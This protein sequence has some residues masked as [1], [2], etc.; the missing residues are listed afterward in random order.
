[1]L[2]SP[3]AEFV[4]GPPGPS[5]PFSRCPNEECPK[6]LSGR[7]RE[8][9][10]LQGRFK[11]LTVAV[12]SLAERE[13]DRGKENLDFFYLAESRATP[14]SLLSIQLAMIFIFGRKR[15][16]GC[17]L[18]K[19]FLPFD[20]NI[21]YQPNDENIVLASN[22]FCSHSQMTKMQDSKKIHH[23]L[24][25]AENHT[26]FLKSTLLRGRLSGVI[27]AKKCS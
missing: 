9:K 10:K 18:T 25:N 20:E 13:D 23:T 27:E 19:I 5:S 14:K 6:F 8:R 26:L 16:W 15:G 1:M 4:R 24:P 17:F 11:K 2:H 21:I 3:N 12:A 7:E 22:F